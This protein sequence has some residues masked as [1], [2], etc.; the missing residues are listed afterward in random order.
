MKM[1]KYNI[2]NYIFIKLTD[3]G[4]ELIIKKHGYSYFE[5]CVESNKREG[6]YYQLQC[7]EVMNYFGEHLY[8]GCKM[9]FEPTVC[10]RR[11]DLENYTEGDNG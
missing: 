10:F 11:A 9:P 2:N 4:K 5:A 1:V 7:H 8:N 3:Y 6:G